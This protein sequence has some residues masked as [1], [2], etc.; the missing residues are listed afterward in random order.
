LRAAALA[1]VVASLAGCG[2]GKAFKLADQAARVGDWET[3]VRYYEQ[4]VEADPNSAEYKI[5]LERARLAASREHLAKAGDLEAKGDL[6][7]AI[8]E[9]RRVTDFDPA[10]RRAAAKVAAL[11]Q[12]LRDRIEAAR[13][14]PAIEQMREK[15]KQAAKEPVLSPTSRQPL[16]VK[17]AAGMAVK[18]ILEFLGPVSG[19]NVLFESTLQESAVTKSAIDLSGVTLEQA[20]TLVMTSNGLFYKVMN[21]KTILV[22]PDNPGNRTK[23]ED[24]V[25]KTIPL[26]HAE[27]Q[28]MMTLLTNIMGG[29]AGQ[30]PPRM[31]INK[32]ANSITIRGG[33]SVVAIAERVIEN[34]DKP[35]AE[36]VIDIEILEVNR[37]RVKQ[38]GLSLSN[39]AI[40]LGFS[41][42]A[43]PGGGTAAGGTTGGAAG[44]SS[45][46]A[47]VA[48]TG[49]TNLNTLA[50]GVS[51]TDFYVALPSA[52]I[53]FLESDSKTKLIAKPSLRGAEGTK[54]TANLGDEI[55][56]PSTSFMPLV[57]G[58]TA[59]NPMTSFTY[60]SVGVNVAV[61]PRVTYDGDII[62]DLEVESSTKGSDVNI[63]GQ[64]LPAF[65]SRKVV[66]RMRLR[67]GESNLLAGLLRDDER[68]SLTGFPGGI[69]V[70]I[71]KQLF[72]GNDEQ[73]SQT[74]IVML[75]T[76]HIIRTQ[77]LTERN[78]EGIYI[79]TAQNPV[80]GGVPPLIGQAADTVAADAPPAGAVAPPAAPPITT[81]PYGTPGAALVGGAPVGRPT[82]AG[83][84]VVP[85]G[86]SPIPGTVM[87]PPAQAAAAT[88]PPTPPAQAAPPVTT[89][90]PAQAT[91]PAATPP[92]AGAAPPPAA[93]YGLPATPSVGVPAQ[94]TITVPGPEW[95]VG[96]GP[97]TVTLSALNM[98]RV[99][100]VTLTLTYNPTALKL[101][102]LQEGSFMRAGVPNTAFA[103]QTDS[104]SGRIDI[105]ISRSGDV[106]GA[107]GSGPLA[108]VV[109]DA[110][111]PG[112]VN[113]RVSGMANGPGGTIP[114]Q[115]TPA[116]VT[117]K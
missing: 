58:G 52:V 77:G 75:L 45:G 110:V 12:T 59:M 108:G 65:G 21:P 51:T 33:A 15:V 11:E 32:G 105:T 40:G 3:A 92:P 29:Q 41:P 37:T 101:R 4:A 31:Q 67:D 84:P 24:Q 116:T 114:L 107:T 106:V 23:Y 85:P 10:N 86:A 18:Q 46:T 71:I 36:V 79:G 53:K 19:I 69:H 117:V 20:L 25:I 112:T 26:S 39:Y 98:T 63:A 17:F 83:T 27:P 50:H 76:P 103:Q 94:V 54:L 47:A 57:A 35:R 16:E 56:V 70:P 44:G 104:A 9:Y 42:D 74:D 48:T 64:N 96:Q 87:M 43:P 2:A 80:L 28:E 115:F 34:N 100:T 89:P 22:I 93:P 109:F 113:F 97:Y 90:P 8:V 62:L 68:K 5:A 78:L 30:Q 6:E 99:S 61:T 66:T 49:L 60:R 95:R 7:G 102:S 13:P 14:K 88:P 81:Q 38:Y 73:I 72:S 1:L 111:A 55:P 82:P 91:P